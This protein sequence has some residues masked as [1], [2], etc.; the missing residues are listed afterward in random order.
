MKYLV[1]TALLLVGCATHSSFSPAPRHDS[2]L[3]RPATT[4]HFQHIV[5]IIQENR[6][7]DQIF[8]G[9]PGADTQSWGYDS[10]GK[11]IQ[12][13]PRP[14]WQTIDPGHGHGDMENAYDGGKMDGFDKVSNTNLLDPSAKKTP[15]Y[16]YSYTQQSDVQP[17]WD[18]ASQG[19]FSN[20]MFQSNMGPSF[21]A[22]QYL[23]AAQSPFASENPAKSGGPWGCDSNAGSTVKA[24]NAQGVE[25]VYGPPCFD[26]QTL[27]D[28]MDAAG[29]SWRYYDPLPKDQWNAYDAIHHIRYGPDWTS[30]AHFRTFQNYTPAQDF[31]SGN[32]A[33]VTWVIPAG[34]DSDHP[35][36]IGDAGPAWVA[37]LVNAIEAGPD[38]S[39]TAVIITH[40]D[41]GG[42]FDH[43]APPVRDVYGPGFRVPLIV[44]SPYT[45]PGSFNSDT[46]DF[47]SILHFVEDNFG[48]GQLSVDDAQADDLSD[49][50]TAQKQ[51]RYKAVRYRG[52]PDYSAR[53]M[54]LPPDNDD[55]ER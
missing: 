40:D 24:L 42:W 55:G 50:F 17:Y 30:G 26:Y 20:R 9:M 33:S 43:V 36:T 48:L 37:S 14:L 16:S 1:L 49:C 11:V 47:G 32:M 29:V 31:Q 8:N 28:E 27:G 13:V 45:T 3:I 23:I 38:A 54:A 22:H 51:V 44:I 2:A 6:S 34:G 5:L 4:P 12:L 18:L 10:T 7:V 39:T 52:Q 46:H 35:N 53:S 15:D 19:N 21:P 41:D 25:Y